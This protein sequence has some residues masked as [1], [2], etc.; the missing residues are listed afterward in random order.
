M[1][2]LVAI[3]PLTSVPVR[4]RSHALHAAAEG[5]AREISL[6][7]RQR[8]D[9][10]AGAHCGADFG[11]GSA[12]WNLPVLGVPVL[13]A[14][15]IE[16]APTRYGN[17]HAHRALQ[18]RSYQVADHIAAGRLVRL[19]P[20]YE[21]PL[22]P[23]HL[24]FPPNRAKKNRSRAG[25]NRPCSARLEVRASC[26]R[27][28]DRTA[29]RRKLTMQDPSRIRRSVCAGRRRSWPARV[30][31]DK[32]TKRMSPFERGFNLPRGPA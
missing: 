31:P 28:H 10:P 24:V 23:V 22:T 18:A 30:S 25:A 19:L 13:P 26:D 32:G 8:H 4:I 11:L 3:L 29:W 14:D 27:L 9:R 20:E 12:A 16:P 7:R 2:Q 6:R 17:H 15:R 1:F 21:R 5:D